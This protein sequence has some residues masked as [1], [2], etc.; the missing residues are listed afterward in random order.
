MYAANMPNLVKFMTP[1]RKFQ[2][3][4]QP[5]CAS[6][7]GPAVPTLCPFVDC[8]TASRCTIS[9]CSSSFFVTCMWRFSQESDTKTSS[10]LQGNH[11][12]CSQE[13]PLCYRR[14]QELRSQPNK[15]TSQKCPCTHSTCSS[16]F[17]LNVLAF[18]DW[19]LSSLTTRP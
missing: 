14:I 11:I 15:K 13:I 3:A 10:G 8:L 7:G 19:L 2:R 6:A 4:Q 9:S 17:S 1:H 18:R 12:Q 16:N 5:T